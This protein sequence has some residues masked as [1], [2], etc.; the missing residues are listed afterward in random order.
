MRI[1]LVEDDVVIAKNLKALISKSSFVVE[2]ASTLGEAGAK[3]E[4]NQ[5]DCI[6]LDRRLPDG[7]GVELIPKIRAKGIYSPIL[8]LTSRNQHQDI[9]EGLNSGADDYLSKPFNI[10]ELIARIRALIRR[11][12]RIPESPVLSIGDL[13]L[14]TNLRLAKRGEIRIALSPREYSILEYLCINQ[15]KVVNRMELIEHVW[16]ESL[17]LFSNTVDVHIRYLRKKIDEGYHKKLIRTVRGKGYVV[18]GK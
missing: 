7:E 14:D 6:V 1:L 13:T 18:C 11:G 17:D 12:E 16:D 4:T 8:V 15:C 3:I 5:Y 2:I 10:E 9:V